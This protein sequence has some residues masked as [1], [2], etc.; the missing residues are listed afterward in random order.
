M[1]EEAR[2]V[3]ARMRNAELRREPLQIARGY[4]VLAK[5]AEAFGGQPSG[6]GELPTA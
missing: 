2:A 1:A 3:A 4:D 6:A 5:R